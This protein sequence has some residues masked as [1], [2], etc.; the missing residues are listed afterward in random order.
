MRKETD[1]FREIVIRRV[2]R[3]DLK[4]CSLIEEV[5]YHGHGATKERIRNRILHYPSGFFVA[6]KQGHLA[7]FIN[8]G[9]IEGES[10]REEK[11][12]DLSG[13]DPKG[14]NSVIFSLAVHPDYQGQGISRLLMEAF[15]SAAR[16]SGKRK[17]LLICRRKLIPYYKKFGFVYRAPSI[18]TWGGYRWHEMGC[19]LEQANH[20]KKRKFNR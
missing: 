13:H 6:I 12:K 15:L 17:I 1:K 2:K 10:I 18:A 16:A 5:C 20:Q 3:S 8:S 7:G 4:G 19:Q 9:C 11:L 14:K